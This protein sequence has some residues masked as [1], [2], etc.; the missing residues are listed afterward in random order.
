MLISRSVIDTVWGS[1]GSKKQIHTTNAYYRASDF[2]ND[3][4]GLKIALWELKVR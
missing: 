3:G 4:P 1:V 2:S